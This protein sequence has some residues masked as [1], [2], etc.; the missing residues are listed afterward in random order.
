MMTRTRSIDT[1]K[2]VATH[3]DHGFGALALF[4]HAGVAE[5]G[6]GAVEP[7]RG[8]VLR[9]DARSADSIK[10]RARLVTSTKLAKPMPR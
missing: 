4:G 8:A 5:D 7:H 1:P 3:C 10:R 2:L 6:A 9:R